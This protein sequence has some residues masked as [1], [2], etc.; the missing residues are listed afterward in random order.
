MLKIEIKRSNAS[1]EDSSVHRRFVVILKK[2]NYENLFFWTPDSR[3][4]E[5]STNIYEQRKSQLWFAPIF[6]FLAEEGLQS[7]EPKPSKI[8][9]FIEHLVAK[10]W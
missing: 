5:E 3:I 2:T 7:Q 1:I 4:L 6:L 10:I 8:E 9:M